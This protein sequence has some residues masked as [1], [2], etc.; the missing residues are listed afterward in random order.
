MYTVN[1]IITMKPPTCTVYLIIIMVLPETIHIGQIP[2]ISDSTICHTFSKFCF[3]LH[4]AYMSENQFM[5]DI[6]VVLLL[7]VYYQYVH[8]GV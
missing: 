3:M 5:A 8:K 4:L 1:C 7:C 6:I 2:Q